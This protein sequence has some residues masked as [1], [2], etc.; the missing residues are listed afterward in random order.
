[1]LM[2]FKIRFSGDIKRVTVTDGINDVTRIIKEDTNSRDLYQLMDFST[3]IGE[4]FKKN[5]PRPAQTAFAYSFNYS[6]L[7]KAMKECSYL[8]I[9]FGDMIF[10]KERMEDD[11]F[12]YL[13]TESV[14]D[15]NEKTWT[16]VKKI[17]TKILK[18]G[19]VAYVIRL[20]NNDLI[21]TY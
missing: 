1:M 5:V 20:D 16:E 7:V 10:K 12:K 11:I 9:G 13:M 19:K 17:I 4:V 15:I 2:Y 3:E 6:D 21:L 14:I 8:R 18:T